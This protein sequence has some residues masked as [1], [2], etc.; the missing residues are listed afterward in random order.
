LNLFGITNR[1][2]NEH[3]MA[4][5]KHKT[6]MTHPDKSGLEPKYFLF[7]KKAF[8]KLKYIYDFQHKSTAAK[9]NTPQEY[10]DTHTEYFDNSIKINADQFAKNNNFNSRFNELFEKN[11]YESEE[12]RTGYGDWLKSEEN[13]LLYNNGGTVRNAG[14]MER[15][16]REKK[17]QTSSLVQYKEPQQLMGGSGGSMLG[18]EKPE[19]YG[20]EDPFSKLKFEDV[21]RA[22]T[23]GSI[24]PV[25]MDEHKK[26]PQFKSVDEFKRY[27]EANRPQVM[28]QEESA[29]ILHREQT[30]EDEMSIHRAY[31]L[32]QEMEEC[33]KRNQAFT[34]SWLLLR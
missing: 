12:T 21:R 32:A 13:D 16:F 23:E 34:S 22:H 24:I 10:K 9:K 7:Y 4:Q 18:G 15:F 25:S 19:H 1:V 20:N 2:V 33:E 17:Q 30:R 29:R 28:S 8:D 27:Q 26:R 11:K 3:D 14:D 5:A 31:L 6:L